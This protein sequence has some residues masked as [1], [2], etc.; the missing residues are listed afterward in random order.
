MFEKTY[1]NYD[2]NLPLLGQAWYGMFL[3]GLALHG[4]DY[5]SLLCPA[6]WSVFYYRK[7]LTGLWYMMA[8]LPTRTPGSLG[9]PCDRPTV[10]LG[11]IVIS[12]GHLVS[13]LAIAIDLQCLDENAIALRRLVPL[14]DIQI[15]PGV[16]LGLINLLVDI[17]IDLHSASL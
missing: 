2:I 5:F 14:K 16:S 6:Q 9:I 15:N 13:L 8:F 4:Q 12:L 1:R 10:C 17:E 11:E 7:Q 3:P